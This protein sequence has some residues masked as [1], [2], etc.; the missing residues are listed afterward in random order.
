MRR[1]VHVGACVRV[2]GVRVDKHRCLFTLP[3]GEKIAPRQVIPTSNDINNQPHSSQER[4]DHT[5]VC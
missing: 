1:S 3:V 4:P 2:H 5:A